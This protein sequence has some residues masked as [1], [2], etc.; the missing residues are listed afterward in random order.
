MTLPKIF[1]TLTLI[2]LISLSGISQSTYR[3]THIAKKIEGKWGG[4][5]PD[6]S[7][8]VIDS[9]QSVIEVKTEKTDEKFYIY[10]VPITM[11]YDDGEEAIVN[12]CHDN[13][14]VKCKFVLRG[15]DQPI[16]EIR[17]ENYVICYLANLIM[18]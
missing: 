16:F 12:L 4:F 13:N 6:H 14:S 1:V 15:K 7:L 17:Y 8:I 11:T 18:N 9:K 2:F 5:I 10:G 3:A